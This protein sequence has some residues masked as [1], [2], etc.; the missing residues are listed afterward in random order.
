MQ[1]EMDKAIRDVLAK[2]EKS[3]VTKWVLVV[4]TVDESGETGLWG[5]TSPGC[6]AWDSLGML[7]YAANLE[8]SNTIVDRMHDG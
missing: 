8:F 6:R 4:E 5:L 1:E 3:I 2:N 7:G